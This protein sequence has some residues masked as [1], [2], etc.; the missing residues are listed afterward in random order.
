MP[1]CRPRPTTSPRA[2]FRPS[3]YALPTGTTSL[4]WRLVCEQAGG[5]PNEDA[6]FLDVYGSSI[7]IA[8]PDPPARP[9]VTGDLGDG[10]GHHGMLVGTVDAFDAGSGVRRAELTF[11][12]VTQTSSPPCDYSMPRPC[13]ARDSF[14]IAADARS[15]HHGP[16]RLTV[17]VTDASGRSTTTSRKVVVGR[18]QPQAF[19][20]AEAVVPDQSPATG[21]SRAAT[22]HAPPSP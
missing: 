16:H 19:A 11:A 14:V 15:L 22:P 4:S 3:G 8:D 13:P 5:C 2:R 10:I 21:G 18:A 1:W 9:T 17:T 20:G 7:T 6:S 12:G